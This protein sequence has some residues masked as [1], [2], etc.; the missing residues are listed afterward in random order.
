MA[1]TSIIDAAGTLRNNSSGAHPSESVLQRPEAMLV[2]NAAKSLIHY[3]DA[4]LD[5][6]T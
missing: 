4:K 6:S 2:I 1:L 3:L 5:D